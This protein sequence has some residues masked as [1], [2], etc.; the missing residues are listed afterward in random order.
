[1]KKIIFLSLS[2]L[3]FSSL[4]AQTLTATLD[5]TFVKWII[6]VNNT[7]TAETPPAQTDYVIFYSTDP[8]KDNILKPQL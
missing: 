6:G 2:Y 3:I 5:G 8:R 1:M 4:N 7:F